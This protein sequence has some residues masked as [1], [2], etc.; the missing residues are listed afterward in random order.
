MSIY[1][2]YK[3]TIS[4][5]FLTFYEDNIKIFDLSKYSNNSY[6]NINAPSFGFLNS[7]YG[8]YFDSN[9]NKIN[10][11]SQGNIFNSDVFINGK[12][13]ATEFP[14]NV[15]ILDSNNKIN[16]SLIPDYI[17]NLSI[18]C[19][20][21]GIG[22]SQALAKLHIKNGDTILENGRLGIGTTIPSYNFH[23]NKNDN[24]SN[25]PAF[26]ITNKGNSSIFDIYAE[27]KLIIINNDG[28]DINSNINLNICGTTATKSLLV[29]SNISFNYDKTIISNELFINNLNSFNQ[30][31]IINCNIDLIINNNSLKSVLSNIND[32]TNKIVYTSNLLLNTNNI[33]T[34]NYNNL[35]SNPLADSALDVKGKLRLYND[36]SIYIIKCFINNLNLYLIT[37]DKKLYEYNLTSK[38]FSIISNNFN[39][40]I[41][42]AKYDLYAYY[43][44][45]TL[46]IVYNSIS[47]SFNN[48]I[49]K[50]FAL[51]NKLANSSIISVYYIINLM[52]LL[53]Y[54]L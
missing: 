50:D 34:S 2:N 46:T 33:I 6:L 24:L 28:N 14:S 40:E 37:N 12:I 32:L 18:S 48:L 3:L 39:Y 44:N 10:F 13:Y 54:L 43:Y 9:T 49:I 1:D 31:I 38:T 4:N 16:S 8:I 15:V 52:K 51:N 17:N 41:F 36:S 22:V 45:Q 30:N 29:S 7:I 27:K 5:N 53:N 23:L 21:I 20:S 42:K 25:I 35:T 11:K 19:N 26:V 47:F